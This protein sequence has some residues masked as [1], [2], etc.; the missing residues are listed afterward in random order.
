MEEVAHFVKNALGRVDFVVG[1]LRRCTLDSPFYINGGLNW[2]TLSP[3]QVRDFRAM[4][5]HSVTLGPAGVAAICRIVDAR[6]YLPYSS[7]WGELGAIP[8]LQ[9]ST[10]QEDETSLLHELESELCP[11]P[12]EM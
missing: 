6:H 1:R 10:V 3:S 12:V 2:L 11:A 8:R 5:S 9:S 7:G 4:R